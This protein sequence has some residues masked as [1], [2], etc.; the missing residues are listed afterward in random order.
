VDVIEDLWAAILRETPNQS[1]PA[2]DAL[3]A[4]LPR[5][6]PP[7]RI[8]ERAAKASTEVFA[9]TDHDTGT[10]ARCR[11]RARSRRCAADVDMMNDTTDLHPAMR[12]RKLRGDRAN[13]LAGC[14]FTRWLTRT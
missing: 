9:I 10:N 12:R 8:V 13:G 3:R 6:D 2:A 7:K 11:V 4:A 1:E 5:S 14:R